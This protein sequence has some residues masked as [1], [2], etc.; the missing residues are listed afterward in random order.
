M[1][2]QGAKIEANPQPLAWQT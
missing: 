1:K 2:T